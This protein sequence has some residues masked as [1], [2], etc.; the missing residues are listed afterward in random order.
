MNNEELPPLEFDGNFKG[1]GFF[2]PRAFWEKV[3]VIDRVKEIVEPKRKE[4]DRTG[5]STDVPGPRAS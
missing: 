2:D 4:G 5:H 3:A 1:Y